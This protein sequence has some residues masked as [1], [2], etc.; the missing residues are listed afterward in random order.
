MY[1]THEELIKEEEEKQ[2]K[3]KEHVLITEDS[4]YTDLGFGDLSESVYI[5]K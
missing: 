3:N 2:K 5:Q 4:T 1:K